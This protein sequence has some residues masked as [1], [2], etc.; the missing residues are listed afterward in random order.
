MLTW[1]AGILYFFHL[2]LQNNE[3]AHGS[4]IASLVAPP[5]PETNYIL[6]SP[7]LS[8]I[9][10]FTTFFSIPSKK[11]ILSKQG[12]ELHSSHI[13]K[14]LAIYGAG[15]VFAISTG[16]YRRFFENLKHDWNEKLQVVEI[17]KGG[18]FWVD[19][20]ASKQLLEEVGVF[21]GMGS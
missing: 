18:H 2:G 7:L 15:D 19:A 10:Y 16:R 3:T 5:I 14:I 1:C 6:I 4:L 11:G 8:P 13:Q 21:I 9:S 17:N 20:K 12:A